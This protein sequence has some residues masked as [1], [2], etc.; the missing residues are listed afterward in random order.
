MGGGQ[1]IRIALTHLGTFAWIGSFSGGLGVDTDQLDSIFPDVQ[2]KANG[3]IRLLWMAHGS[4]ETGN[5]S[6]L[7]HG[8]LDSR[9]VRNTAVERPGAHTMMNWRR[10]VIEFSQLL[11]RDR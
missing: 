6:R 8:W 9:G 3:A 4:E 10:N 7:M 5:F 1:A 2:T 11:F